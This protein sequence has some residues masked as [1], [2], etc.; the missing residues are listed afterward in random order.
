MMLNLVFYLFI[1]I[2][3]AFAAGTGNTVAVLSASTT[4]TSEMQRL[5]ALK[6]RT[7]R[8]QALSPDSICHHMYML[9]VLS[10]FML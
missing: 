9:R 1:F 8:E 2:D 5:Q 4:E 7:I 6:S 10:T 3:G